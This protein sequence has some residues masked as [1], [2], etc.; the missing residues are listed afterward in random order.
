MAGPKH[1]VGYGAS[2]GGRDYD[3]AYISDSELYNVYLPPFAAAI[4]AGAGNIMSAY[5]DFNDVPASANKRLLTDI[6]RGELG[7]KG[8]VVTDASAVHNL[9]K[10]GFATDKADAAAKAI[11]AGVDMEMSTPANAFAT[12]ADSVRAGKVPMKV[13]D[14][15]VRRVLVVKYEMGLFQNPYVDA[16]AAQKV[17]E[18][19]SHAAASQAAAERALVLL[20]NDGQALPL[21][22][23]AQ[24]RTAG[25]RPRR[26]HH[27][28]GLP[29]GHA[30]RDHGVQ[31]R[32]RPPQRRRLR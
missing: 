4:R 12:L 9:V 16:A 24:K 2:T 29:P 19:P 6:L 13:V 25:G 11:L 23:G 17:L 10:Q 30:E 28:A 20:K 32:A 7:F 31:R 22:A 21:V 14:D 27:L 8:F 26:H 3:S 1:F 15:A 18:D 5:M